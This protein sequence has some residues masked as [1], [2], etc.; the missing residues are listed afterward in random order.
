MNIEK[1]HEITLKFLDAGSGISEYGYTLLKR[2]IGRFEYCDVY[3]YFG[4]GNT[5][6]LLT[7]EYTHPENIKKVNGG[8][9]YG[10]CMVKVVPTIYNDHHKILKEMGKLTVG[11]DRDDLHEVNTQVFSSVLIYDDIQSTVATEEQIKKY[12]D[13]AYSTPIHHVRISELDEWVRKQWRERDL[14]DLI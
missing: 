5:D 7:F 8:W 6:I 13:S 12:F 2:Q 9:R 14:E 4:V 1:Y 11:K 10:Y 3:A